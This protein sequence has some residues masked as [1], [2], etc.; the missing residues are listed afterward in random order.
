MSRIRHKVGA[1][2]ILSGR[3][4]DF[5]SSEYPPL[6]RRLYFSAS[7]PPFRKPL[8]YSGRSRVSRAYHGLARLACSVVNALITALCRYQPFAVVRLQRVAGG[9]SLRR[10]SAAGGDEVSCANSCIKTAFCFRH[11]CKIIT[12]IFTLPIQSE[13]SCAIIKSIKQEAV[14]HG[15]KSNDRFSQTR[16]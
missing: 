11:K 12:T 9:F 13:K 3:R 10:S 6:K 7:A 16:I 15:G 14:D 5:L 1:D 2:A 4:F 8:R